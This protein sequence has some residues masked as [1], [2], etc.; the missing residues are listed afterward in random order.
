MQII[1]ELEP[2]AREAYCGAIGIIGLDGR[3]TLNVAIRTMVL[4]GGT[5]HLYAGGAITADSDPEAEYAECL[6]KAEGLMRSIGLTPATSLRP[7]PGRLHRE[8]RS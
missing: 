7:S 5:A 8:E 1:R 6:A 3:M 2:T 4:A